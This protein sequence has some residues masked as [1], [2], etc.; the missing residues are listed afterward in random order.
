M[1]FNAFK[2]AISITEEDS[3]RR[4]IFAQEII[5]A[6]PNDTINIIAPPQLERSSDIKC[7]RFLV[8]SRLRKDRYSSD[9]QIDLV[10]GKNNARNIASFDIPKRIF[11]YD[12]ILLVDLD[13]LVKPYWVFDMS[14]LRFLSH[15][16][17]MHSIIA[18][19]EEYNEVFAEIVVNFFNIALF[20][21]LDGFFQA[22]LNRTHS[23]VSHYGIKDYL[24][25]WP[26]VF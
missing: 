5:D 1:G 12:N 3:E 13:K 26:S 14:S 10:H 15:L 20:H 17:A 6:L 4:K 25:N 2:E 11:E 7:P 9:A 18:D 24:V 23:H 8:Y 22:I 19:F 21:S 16:R